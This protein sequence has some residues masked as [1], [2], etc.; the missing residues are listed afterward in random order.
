MLKKVFLTGIVLLVSLGVVV[1]LQPSEFTITRSVT[2]SAPP[3]ILFDEVNNFHRWQEWSP[4]EKID[5]AMTR[6]FSGA[7]SGLG[8]R[9]SWAGNM[10]A[11][12]GSMT[13]IE[14]RSP[15]LIRIRLEFI[16]PFEDVCATEFSFRSEASAAEEASSVLTTVTWTMTGEN[17]FVSKAFCL[18]MDMD[19]EVGGQFEK[20]LAN[21]KA[22]SEAFA[23]AVVLE[24]NLPSDSA[25]AVSAPGDNP[26]TT[27]SR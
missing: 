5:P 24:A 12:A 19:K 13:I 10:E 4:W 2:V 8:A 6:Q 14:S 26:A 1:H 25:L 17:D 27:P 20:G 21:L 16:K 23:A 9:Y 3:S 15:E 7:G 22:R 18:V 11:G